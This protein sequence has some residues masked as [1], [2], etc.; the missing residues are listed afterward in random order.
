MAYNK[1]NLTKNKDI[2]QTRKKKNLEPP[3]LYAVP[4]MA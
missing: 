3:T 4:P 2:V 1:K